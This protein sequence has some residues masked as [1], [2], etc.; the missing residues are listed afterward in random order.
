M[1]E[2]LINEIYQKDTQASSANGIAF[3]KNKNTV[4][5]TGTATAETNF[6]ILNYQNAPFP[7]E[8]GQYNI[9]GGKGNDVYFR[10]FRISDNSNLLLDKGQGANGELKKGE[11]YLFWLTVNKGAVC[12]NLEL[13]LQLAKGSIVKPFVENNEQNYILDIQEPM[14]TGDYFDLDRKKEVHGWNKKILTG[15]E[16]TWQLYT[17]GTR[18]FGLDITG[19]LPKIITGKYGTGYCTHFKVL[20]TTGTDL[21]MF[22][23]VEPNHFYIAIVDTNSRWSDVTALKNELQELY[24]AGTPIEIYYKTAE[25]TELD[26]TEAQIKALE[27][28]NKL[29]FYKNVNNI[30]TT[31]DIAL[32]QA[33]YSVNLKSA[34][35]KMQQQI[36]EIKELL[37]TTQTSAMLINNLQ[38]DLV[39][40]VK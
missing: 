31:E 25:T 16:N 21:T 8:T 7:F 20:T 13:N 32:L 37:S 15:T 40:E 24:N 3:Q 23:Q 26:L 10:V 34:N 19:D 29:R 28:L 1:N 27:Q 5:L 30:M 35:E 6:T 4:T 17:T 14:L 22:L 18:R 39:E 2:N 9:S 12:N 33:E 38:K 36:D 11:K